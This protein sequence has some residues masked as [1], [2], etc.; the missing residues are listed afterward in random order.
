[1]LDPTKIQ[2]S[3]ILSDQQKTYFVENFTSMPDALKSQLQEL[4]EQ[5][6][7]IDWEQEEQLVQEALRDLKELA[8]IRFKHL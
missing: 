8:A 7:A 2:S 5:E 3:Q 6:W 1:M 4:L